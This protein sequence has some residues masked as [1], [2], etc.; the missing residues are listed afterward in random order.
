VVASTT[1]C[2]YPRPGNPN[3]VLV[4]RRGTTAASSTDPSTAGASE[5]TADSSFGGR[6]RAD[7]VN[8]PLAARAPAPIDW[9]HHWI[10]SRSSRMDRA[11][12]RILACQSTSEPSGA[13]TAPAWETESSS[14]LGTS[15]PYKRLRCTSHIAQID[16]GRPR[17]QRVSAGAVGAFGRAACHR[18][19]G[20]VLG[21]QM[22]AL[23]EHTSGVLSRLSR[24]AMQGRR[25]VSER[26]CVV[27]RA[28]RTGH[29]R[30]RWVVGSHTGDRFIGRHR[31]VREA[32]DTVG[33]RY[34]LRRTR[35]V[36]AH[37]TSPHFPREPSAPTVSRRTVGR[38]FVGA[39]S[40]IAVS[41]PRARCRQRTRGRS[42][43]RYPLHCRPDLLRR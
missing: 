29:C 2:A 31:A 1:T 43:P 23:S 18:P 34:R 40:A 28:L 5:R 14:R 17:Q 8:R 38:P 21:S 42:P 3:E 20:D 19:M 32:V 27:A 24:I 9:P 7:S 30:S 11:T 13:R 4:T 33:S 22:T 12:R 35:S 10:G 6:V 26:P 41:P 15:G 36:R 25:R 16:R 37:P 39:T